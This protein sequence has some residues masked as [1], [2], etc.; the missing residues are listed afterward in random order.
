VNNDPF[1]VRH[2]RE[3]IFVLIC[4]MTSVLLPLFVTSRMK[5]YSI[6]IIRDAPAAATSPDFIFAN[7]IPQ[8]FRWKN[9]AFRLNCKK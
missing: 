4:D 8:D 9:N 5:V 6:D 3:S 1:I 2:L 7:I